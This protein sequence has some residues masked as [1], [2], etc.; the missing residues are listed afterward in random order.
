VRLPC[1]LQVVQMSYQSRDSSGIALGYGLDVRGL[2]SRQGPG[3]LLSI[4]TSRQD[5]EPIQ[6]PIQWG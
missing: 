4:T 5:L 2:E 6:P 3:V 1:G